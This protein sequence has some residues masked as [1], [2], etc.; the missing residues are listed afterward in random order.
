MKKR[1]LLLSYLLFLLPAQAHAWWN[2]DWS[3]RKQLTL[4]TTAAGADI[5]GNLEEV[6]VLVRLHT[7]NFNYFLDLKQD[8]SDLRFIAGDDKTPLKY[9]IEKFDP[10]NQMALIWV[11][12]PK[13]MGTSSTNSLWMYYGNPKAAKA[14]DAAGTYGVHQALVYHFENATGAPKDQTGYAN[15]PSQYTAQTIPTG[16]IGGGAH[17]SGAQRIDIPDTAS[18]AIKP[19]AGWTFSAW[20]KIDVSQKDAYVL[21]RQDGTRS[22]AVGIDGTAVYARY[23]DGANITQTPAGASLTT[24]AWHLLALT[25]GQGRLTLYIDGQ[26]GAAVPA[27][28]GD[29]G[30]D[31][32]IGAA[33][34][35]GH[36]FSGDLDEVEIANTARSVE[37]LETMT[38]SQGVDA[39]LITYGSDE[40]AD[41]GGSSSTLPVILHSVTLDGWVVIIILAAM[42]AVSWVV[43]LGKGLVIRR[44]HKDN[45]QFLAQFRKLDLTETAN[46]DQEE[47]DDE[48]ELEG[49]PLLNALVGKHDHFQSSPLYRLYHQ[50]IHELKQRV[51]VAVGAQ[52]SG[53]TAKAMN[54][55]RATLDAVMVRELQ[56]INA[57]M[58]LLTIAISGG[59]FLGLLGTVMGVMITF[60]N[61][62]ATGDVNVNAIAPGIAAALV[63]TVAGLA[64]AIPALFGYNS[65]ASR[66]KTISSDMHVFVDE[67][68]TKTEELYGQ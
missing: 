68:V 31:T 18:L 12:M 44:I 45:Q 56:K 30:G 48:K 36:G 3:F 41:S 65:L 2:N 14:E 51:G 33:A 54:A 26:E 21:L 58:V 60:A 15:H 35:G 59:P 20:V 13:L 50:G 32:V 38:R 6:P 23:N 10:V 1:L 53:I 63:A 5:K 64:V 61:I 11:K 42:A 16:L 7:G 25:V 17:F 22:L 55:I 4:D 19:D 46:L 8:A 28:M 47:T 67:F 24:G 43:M 39:K 37:W 66:I 49:S 52:A 9:H 40:Q 57:Q 62:A 29:M 34:D 27:P